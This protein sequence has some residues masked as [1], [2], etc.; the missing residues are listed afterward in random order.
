MLDSN[1]GESYSLLESIKRSMLGPSGPNLL[2]KEEKINL[3]N[4]QMLMLE[5]S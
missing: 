5:K 4:I 3:L 1:I 2:L